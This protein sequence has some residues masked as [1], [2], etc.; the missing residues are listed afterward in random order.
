MY[1]P[2]DKDSERRRFQLDGQ[3]W[4]LHNE[5]IPPQEKKT[6]S[7]H[8]KVTRENDFTKCSGQSHPRGVGPY[9]TKFRWTNNIT[10]TSKV[11]RIAFRKDWCEIK[12]AKWSNYKCNITSDGDG[13]I[14]YHRCWRIVKSWT[15]SLPSS[16]HWIYH[17][18]VCSWRIISLCF[19]S[20]LLSFSVLYVWIS[21]DRLDETRF[22]AFER[23][24][25][26]A[27]AVFFVNGAQF[28]LVSVCY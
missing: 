23:Q 13:E 1:W 5:V 20:H 14:Q 22:Y 17:F 16:Q 10:Q 25:E 7:Q 26:W 28:E 11:L 3:K 12:L 2:H 4:P 19:V 24:N 15:L 27:S 8:T 18:F 6:L 21:I 9:K